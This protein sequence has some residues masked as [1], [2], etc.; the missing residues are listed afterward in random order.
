VE[1]KLETRDDG[2]ILMII[3]SGAFHGS[4][5]VELNDAVKQWLEA[6]TV[7]AYSIF[8]VMG[9]TK[10]APD[11]L[12]A[13]GVDFLDHP[14]LLPEQVVYGATTAVQMIGNIFNKIM[15]I[16]STQF[17]STQ[18]EAIALARQYLAQ[19]EAS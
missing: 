18:E 6:Q 16:K 4:D 19:Q 9:L 5:V 8:D 14:M 3:V 17:V 11:I 2:R 1:L 15:H 10:V 12:Y 7:P 13:R